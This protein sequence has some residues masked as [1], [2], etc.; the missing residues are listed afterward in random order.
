M[1]S[2]TKNKLEN[3]VIKVENIFE[4]NYSQT[5]KLETAELLNS[6][7]MQYM[8]FNRSNEIIEP[9]VIRQLT[10]LVIGDISHSRD[11]RKTIT[12][13]RD[14]FIKNKNSVSLY[15]AILQKI[16]DDSNDENICT[17]VT[18]L[19][20][21]DKN[22]YINHM[23]N[24]FQKR[25]NR[26]HVINP[27]IKRFGLVPKTDILDV[28]SLIEMI[29]DGKTKGS[30][31]MET[32]A[33]KAS[34]FFVVLHHVTYH[35]IEYNI[36][37]LL[38]FKYDQPPDS[39]INRRLIYRFDIIRSLSDHELKWDFKYNTIGDLAQSK[40]YYIVETLDGKKY[41][42]LGYHDGKYDVELSI[43]YRIINYYASD[44]QPDRV[45]NY[46][47]IMVNKALPNMFIKRKMPVEYI[48]SFSK[49]ID[50]TI[51][52]NTLSG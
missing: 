33:K 1:I 16:L 31:K 38:D 40:K 20:E 3:S 8:V 32:Y 39:G 14:A 21:T 13:I 30:I 17:Y 45:S 26:A 19:V 5:Y 35:P 43:I 2:Q 25:H 24:Y 11:I 52:R 15:A 9:D 10:E 42:C 7:I 47:N 46:H 37:R 22:L 27:P 23:E 50:V 51:I 36:S 29:S 44:N 6:I 34:A 49:D 28:S 48:E 12:I 4:S 18:M 41:R